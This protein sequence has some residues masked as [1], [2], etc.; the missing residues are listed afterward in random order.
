MDV[1][2]VLEDQVT[3]VNET[4]KASQNFNTNK[5]KLKQYGKVVPIGIELDLKTTL[6]HVLNVDEIDHVSKKYPH[7]VEDWVKGA[8]ICASN[9]FHVLNININFALVQEVDIK[10]GQTFSAFYPPVH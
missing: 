1:V 10:A 7:D 2:H 5:D 9:D 8:T 6:I 3:N 4:M